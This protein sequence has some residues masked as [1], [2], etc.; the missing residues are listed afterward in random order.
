MKNIIIAAA[1]LAGV[2]THLHAQMETQVLRQFY[3]NP[4]LLN[5]GFIGSSDQLEL[6]MFY[7][8]QWIG[9]KEAPSMLGVS[10][11]LPAGDRVAIGF[12]VTSDNQVILKNTS[13]TGTFG[14]LV[15][16]G[17]EHSLRF[18][19]SAGVGMNRFDFTPEELNS[20]DP[21]IQRA[22]RNTMAMQG[23]FGVVYHLKKLKLGFALTEL[24]E[25]DPFDEATHNRF[26][27]RSLKN[28]LFSAS[29]RFDLDPFQNFQMEPYILYNQTLDRT[30]DYLEGAAIVYYH[31]KLWA[32]ASYNDRHGIALHFGMELMSKLTF[33]YSYEF[34]PIGAGGSVS[35]SH[36][37][38]LRLSLGERATPSGNNP[39]RR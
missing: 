4:Y 8:K 9:I 7:K 1:M 15:P 18:A 2:S 3:S 30:H 26:S 12:N 5:P 24:F 34:P 10:L 21:A 35:N 20:N 38:H 22:S 33:N 36:E 13:A 28:R 31:R 11:Q 17:K 32:G 23:N 25:S 19:L 16:L 6:N 14:Y 27:M 39:R 29:Y 37:L